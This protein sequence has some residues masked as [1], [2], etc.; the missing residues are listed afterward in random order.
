MPT[1][2][3][4]FNQEE[5]KNKLAGLFAEHKADLTS[6]GL[7]VNQTFEAAIFAKTINWHKGNGWSIRIKNP[8][9]KGKETFKLK[10]STR[11]AP[12]KYTYA[13]CRN[14]DREIEIRHQLRVRTKHQPA[15]GRTANIC[16]DIAIIKRQTDL[17]KMPTD[18]AIV[19]DDLVSFG[20]VKHMSAFPELIA[21]FIGLVHELY[22]ARLGEKKEKDSTGSN[23]SLSP[24]LYLSG[25]LAGTA[26]ALSESIQDRGYE[27]AIYHVKNDMNQ[28]RK[29]AI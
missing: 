21:S 28:V 19:N 17:D 5:W 25:Y 15:S 12:G 10:F 20:E 24:F 1:K 27:V 22:P 8:K 9:R 23:T 4:S 7:R 26:E 6:F 3:Y 13:I 29:G 14:N 2:T 18:F 11:G 16:C